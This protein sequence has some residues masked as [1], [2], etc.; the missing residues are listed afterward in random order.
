[1]RSPQYFN[2]NSILKWHTQISIFCYE[3]LYKLYELCTRLGCLYFIK[4]EN[5]RYDERK[6]DTIVIPD[7][8]V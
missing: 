8:L 1:M 2:F 6:Y 3:L 4:F 5:R 7:Y